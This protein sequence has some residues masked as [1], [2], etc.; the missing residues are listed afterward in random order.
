METRQSVLFKTCIPVFQHFFWVIQLFPVT[1]SR[2]YVIQIYFFVQVQLV[3]TSSFH[4]HIKIF[5]Q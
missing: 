5:Q 1:V 4:I 2:V 3:T